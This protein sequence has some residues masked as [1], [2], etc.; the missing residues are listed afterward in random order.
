MQH[1]EARR[2]R[3]EQETRCYAWI[4]YVNVQQMVRMIFENFNEVRWHI[5]LEQQRNK[6]AKKIQKEIKAAIIRK[7]GHPDPNMRIMLRAK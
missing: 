7:G 4:T 3:N 2:I 5:R 6:C 1:E